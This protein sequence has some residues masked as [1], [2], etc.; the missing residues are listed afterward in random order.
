LD[1]ARQGAISLLSHPRIP[2]ALD[3]TKA[4]DQVLDRYGRNAFGWSLFMAQ[5]QQ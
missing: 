1:H 5:T 4:A 2:Q 3:V